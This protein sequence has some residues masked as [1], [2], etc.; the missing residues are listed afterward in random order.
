MSGIDKMYF[1]SFEQW[2]QFYNWCK[3][4]ELKIKKK[5]S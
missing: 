2:E 1:E 3:S 4:H 5:T